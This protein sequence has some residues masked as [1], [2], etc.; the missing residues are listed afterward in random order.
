MFSNMNLVKKRPSGQ[1]HYVS[2]DTYLKL[3]TTNYS[4]G[5]NKICSKI[6]S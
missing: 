4:P 2:V 1:P 5:L 3:K 6:R